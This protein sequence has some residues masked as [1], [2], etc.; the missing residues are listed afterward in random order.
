MKTIVIAT[1]NKHKLEEFEQLLKGY[2]LLT[3]G[4]VGF[5]EDV[6][7]N[8]TT[9]AEN[10]KIKALACYK[11][12]RKNGLNYGVIADDTGLF[13][14]ALHGAPG[15]YSARYA[16]N[17]DSQANRQKLLKEMEEKT[18]RSAYFECDICYKDDEVEKIFVG[19]AFGKITT[20]IIG[21]TE[22]GYDPIF[23]SDDLNKTFGECGKEEKD[24]VSHRG[25]AANELKAFL[26]EK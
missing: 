23:L 22:F 20:E 13:V 6:E 16:G 12:L 2:K 7:E 8:G 1:N 25:R 9:L 5:N 24:T 18:N 11:F 26:S 15:I 10:A 17:H 3:L 21:S 4:D 19:R 14:N